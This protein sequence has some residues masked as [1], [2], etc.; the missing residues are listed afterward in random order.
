ME[1]IKSIA[2]FWSNVKRE[3]DSW[4]TLPESGV[5][6]P[7]IPHTKGGLTPY[8]RSDYFNLDEFRQL[9]T[10]ERMLRDADRKGLPI[11][12]GGK[13]QG[14]SRVVFELSPK[15]VLKIGY[16]VFGIDQNRKEAEIQGKSPIFTKVYDIDPRMFWIIAEKVIPFESDEE[17]AS[18]AGFSLD[19][20]YEIKSLIDGGDNIATVR[21]Y[22]ESAFKLDSSKLNFIFNIYNIV[23]EENLLHGDLFN[24]KHWGISVVDGRLKVF[25]Y[26]ADILLKNKAINLKKQM[27][28]KQKKMLSN[29]QEPSDGIYVYDATDEDFEETSVS[30]YDS[31]RASRID[32]LVKLAESTLGEKE[33][34]KYE[35]LLKKANV[36]VD[37]VDNLRMNVN[38]KADAEK[39]ELIL[40]DSGLWPIS[41][42]DFWRAYKK[43]GVK[44]GTKI[45][46]VLT[47]E[48]DASLYL[49]DK[50][51]VIA[52]NK[53]L[54][55]V[56]LRIQA[57]L[58][59]SLQ[60]G[61]YK[62]KNL[63][64]SFLKPDSNIILN[65]M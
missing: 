64:I 43:A 3:R 52:F 30:A 58:K 46:L 29:K 60:K 7:Q 65:V 53:E 40:T 2:G 61:T 11:L 22:V 59:N 24:P 12:M 51:T 21:D 38:S 50:T 55:M 1:T 10:K 8:E 4:Q 34:S 17:F 6:Q 19:I 56:L 62:N 9:P 42:D 47:P 36:F 15:T 35:Q 33:M 13:G 44:P 37:T 14:S 25:D 27:E 20:L 48:M 39:V 63:N 5:N 31:R 49:S 54:E 57:T 26:G 23:K 41:S 18:K 28:E 32:R 16:G 45:N